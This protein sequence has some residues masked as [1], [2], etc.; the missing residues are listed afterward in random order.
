MTKE[1]YVVTKELATKVLKTV[2][3]GLVKGI[4]APSPGAM[5][6]EAAVCYAM[7]LPHSDSPTCVAPAVRSFKIG[8]NDADWSSNYARARGLRQI[9]VAQLGSNTIDEVAFAKQVALETIRK[10]VPMAMLAAASI[11]T[12]PIHKAAL[13]KAAVT[14]EKAVD[15]DAARYASY[16]ASYAASAASYAAS[17][18]S[19]A[20]SAARA[21]ASYAASAARAA[22]YA[23]RA[24]ARDKVLT[25]A[26]DIGRDAL[27]ACNSPG[28]EF[29]PLCEKE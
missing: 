11:Q 13:E 28:C 21:A 4:G 7:G 9:A 25:C 17:A 12:S 6:V 3:R 14:C 29:L 15:L 10:I 8:L 26:A 24:A 5:C 18:A 23:A 16:A 2:D 19:Y 1:T 27:I 20:A 22:S